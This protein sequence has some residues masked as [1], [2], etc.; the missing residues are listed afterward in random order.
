[1]CMSLEPR[2][3]KIGIISNL[4]ANFETEIYKCTRNGQ[5]K[6]QIALFDILHFCRTVENAKYHKAYFILLTFLKIYN[7]GMKRFYIEGVGC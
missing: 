7:S 2:S 5:T 1:M 6:P 4:D 3:M